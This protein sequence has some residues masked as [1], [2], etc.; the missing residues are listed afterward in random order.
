MWKLPNMSEAEFN[1]HLAKKRLIK[2]SRLKEAEINTY[3]R[4]AAQRA[5]K[6]RNK[7]MS[8]NTFCYRLGK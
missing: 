8:H 1:E 2:E 6:G 4:E 5:A 7:Y 3:K